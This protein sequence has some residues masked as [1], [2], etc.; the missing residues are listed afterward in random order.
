M[1]EILNEQ[2][3]EMLVNFAHHT[4]AKHTVEQF[5]HLIPEMAPRGLAPVGD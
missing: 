4:T 2:G 5:A 3:E 1:L